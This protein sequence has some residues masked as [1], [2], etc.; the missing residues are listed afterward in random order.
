MSANPLARHFA[1]DIRFYR[2]LTRG[3]DSGLASLVATMLT[4]R[5]LWLVTFHRVGNFCLRRRNLAS[6]LWWLA[7]LCK[8]AG[9]CFNMLLCRSEVSEDCDI[10]AGV[11]LANQGYILCGARSIGSGSLVHERCT[12]GALA[13]VGGEGRPAIGRNVWVGPDCI[14]AGLLTVGDGATILPGS[15]VTF[16]VPPRAVVKG[17]PAVIVRRDFDNSALLSSLTVAADLGTNDS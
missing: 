10:G 4:N 13:A 9:T 15:F 5:G 6:P 12:F 2:G 11:Y 8:G 16:S 3:S 1:A 17:N 14:M 7:R